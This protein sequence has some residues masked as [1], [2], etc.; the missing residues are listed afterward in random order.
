MY[1]DHTNVIKSGTIYS[2]KI[3][4]IVTIRKL[5]TDIYKAEIDIANIYSICMSKFIPQLYII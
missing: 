5:A 1:Y 3:S 2:E 4:C